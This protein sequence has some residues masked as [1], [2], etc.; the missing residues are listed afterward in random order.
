MAGRRPISLGALAELL[1][2]R[3]VGEAERRVDHV[4]TLQNAGPGALTFLANPRYRPLLRETRAGAVLL[5]EEH[6]AACTTA[7]LICDDPYVAYARAAQHLHPPDRRPSGIHPRAWVDPQAEVDPGAAIGPQVTV[8]AGAVIAAGVV[9]EPGCVVGAGARIGTDSW[10][11]A[12]VSIGPGCLLGARVIVH[13]GAVIGAD[14][15]G[16]ANDAGHWVKIPQIGRVVVGDDVEIGA[17]TTID[18]GALDDTVI[19]EGVKLDNLIQIAHNVRIGAHTAMAGKS[20]VAGSTR[21]GRHCAIGGGSGIAGH[22]EIGDGAQVTAM[23]LI[24]NNVPAGAVYSSG[25]QMAPTRE[26]RR[27]AVRFNQLDDMARRLRV[28]ERRLAE[29]DEEQE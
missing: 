24:T 10:I 19:E 26:W 15:F 23:S 18:R 21:I 20:G 25:T 27:N 5:H 7:A 16:F 29:R 8:E 9:L 3:L 11:G 2:V 1:G 17:N 14:G 28:L 4:A 13:A 12:N 22:L 6:A